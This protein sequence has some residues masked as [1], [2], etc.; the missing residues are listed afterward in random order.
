MSLYIIRNAVRND[1]SHKV[2]WTI[3]GAAS[4]YQYYKIKQNLEYLNIF[5]VASTFWFLVEFRLSQTNLRQGKIQ[6][7]SIFGHELSKFE[8]AILR[9]TAEGGSLT[10]MGLIAADYYLKHIDFANNKQMAYSLGFMMLLLNGMTILASPLWNKQKAF[11]ASKRNILDRK[12]LGVMFT[13]IGTLIWGLKTDKISTINKERLW[14]FFV[15]D[16]A[17]GVSW[18]FLAYFVGYRWLSRSEDGKKSDQILDQLFGLVWDGAVEISA[19]YS[20]FVVL[21]FAFMKNK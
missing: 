5:A 18:N 16:A 2:L 4:C 10:L 7:G 13:A 14:N 17:I 3:S 11:I 12:S 1:Y 9:G 8:A 21:V 19:M 15:F 6:Q 20:V